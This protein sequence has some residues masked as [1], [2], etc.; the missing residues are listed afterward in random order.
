LI[1]YCGE[2]EDGVFIQVTIESILSD[3]DG[4]QLLAEGFFL[5]CVMMTLVDEKIPG[6]VRERL[7]VSY[8]R[9]MVCV[10]RSLSHSFPFPFL[11]CIEPS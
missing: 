9:Y 11:N 4:K 10:C 5:S 7:I 2:V 8:L 3:D 6:E 1:K